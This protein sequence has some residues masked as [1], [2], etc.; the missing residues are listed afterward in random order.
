MV[1]KAVKG[2]GRD[3][4]SDLARVLSSINEGMPEAEEITGNLP[5][6]D[7]H[8]FDDWVALYTKRVGTINHEMRYCRVLYSVFNVESFSPP[9]SALDKSLG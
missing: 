3:V 2:N 4:S 9:V 7:S 1:F 8:I 6:M 5:Y